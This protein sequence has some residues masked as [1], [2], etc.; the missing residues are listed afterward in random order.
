MAVKAQ[1]LD[2][3][4]YRLLRPFGARKAADE[5][6]AATVLRERGLMEQAEAHS[7]RAFMHRCYAHHLAREWT[8]DAEP[9]IRAVRGSLS[10][11]LGFLG[12][13]IAAKLVGAALNRPITRWQARYAFKS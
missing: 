5:W 2:E 11:Q 1:G 9:L 4:V 3:V 10:W 8:P 7:R 13:G 12:Y 6:R